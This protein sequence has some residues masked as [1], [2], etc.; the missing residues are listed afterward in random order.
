MSGWTSG[1]TFPAKLSAAKTWRDRRTRRKR[2]K[3]RR[4]RS[5]LASLKFNFPAK[6]CLVNL[7][8]EPLLKGKDHF[9][10]LLALTSLDQLIVIL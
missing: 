1:P 3:R 10:D 9:S 6:G 4:T 8:L 7:A 2:P 5:G